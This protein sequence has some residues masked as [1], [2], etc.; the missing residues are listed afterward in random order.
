MDKIEI[1]KSF[2][3]RASERE[4]GRWRAEIRKADGSKLRTLVGDTGHQDSI[5]TS[6]DRLTAQ[7]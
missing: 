7:A 5:G 2:E 6:A 3:I 1:Y 4:Q